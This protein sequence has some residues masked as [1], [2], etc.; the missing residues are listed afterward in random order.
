GF[1]RVADDLSLIRFDYAFD[2]D[3]NHL[4]LSGQR[5]ANQ[6]TVIVRSRGESTP[7]VIPLE[8]Q[9]YPASAIGLYPFLHG[10]EVGRR[11]HY[12]VYD[13]QTQKLAPVV[14]EILAYEESELFRGPA[15]K[16]RT[17]FQGG[18]VTTWMNDRGEPLLEMSLNGVVISVLESEDVARKYLAQAAL[19]KD[20]NMLEFSL[21]KCD[22]VIS[23]PDRIHTLIVHISGLSDSVALP[24]NGRQV[25]THSRNG[26]ICRLSTS[27]EPGNQGPVPLDVEALSRYLAPTIAI[28]AQHPQISSLAQKIV[29]G[30]DGDP[31]RIQALLD[32][33]HQNIAREPVDVFTA[34]DVLKGGRAECQGHALL[35]AAFARTL[36][37]P[38]RI[39]NGIVYAPDFRGFLYHSWNESIVDGR[40][41]AVDP[42]L[43]QIPADATHIKLLEG[44]N[45][46]DLM[47]LVDMIGQLKVRILSTE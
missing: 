39:V 45:L 25:C 32:W 11:Y 36:G 18:T 43:G 41:V 40:W 6:L 30:A 7:Q 31:Q 37:I 34:L 28:S 13:G 22:T 2:I 46:S 12:T 15:F 4:S 35:Y 38:T 21:I 14:Q 24:N 1:D 27:P 33:I 29:A 42:T 10:L 8:T 17:R 26:S 16:I 44:Q 5:L 19:N 23:D 9:I 47:P 3:G 20:E